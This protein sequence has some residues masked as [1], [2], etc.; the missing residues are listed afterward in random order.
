MKKIFCILMLVIT[1]IVKAES[2]NIYETIETNEDSYKNREKRVLDNLNDTAKA[3]KEANSWLIEAKKHKNSHQQASAYKAIMH[4]V[5]KKFRMIY[6]D[7]LLIKAKESK[8]DIT[9]GSA[10][11]TVGA[12]FYDNKEYTKALDNYIITRSALLN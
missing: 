4:L 9:L 7:S 10:Y 11:L 12:A 8:N 3:L 6:A 1:V 5:E 2:K